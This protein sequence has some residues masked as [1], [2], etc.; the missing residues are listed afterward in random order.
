[1]SQS[2]PS[3]FADAEHLHAVREAQTQCK[4]HDD[5]R[6]VRVFKTL[7]ESEIALGAR[8]GDLEDELSKV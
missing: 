1:M 7:G 6:N 8:K 4:K 3:G 5:R 2:A